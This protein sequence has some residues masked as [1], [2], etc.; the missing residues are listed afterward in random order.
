MATRRRTATKVSRPTNDGGAASSDAVV[1]R[2]MRGIIAGVSDASWSRLAAASVRRDYA[3]GE[4]IFAAG[5]PALGLFVV[6]AGQVRVMR[7]GGGR[8][9]VLHLEGAGATLGEAPM[10]ESLARGSVPEPTYPGT[11]VAAEPTACLYVSREAV[12]AAVRADP[13]LAFALLARLAARVRHFADRMDE[14][15]RLPA[16]GRLASLLL[17]RH[18]A[19]RG[20][21]FALAPTQQH[22][23]EELGTVREIVVRDEPALRALAEPRG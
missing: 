15:A 9:F 5:A 19:S 23:A 16:V 13:D 6:V 14:R 22:A 21:S 17:Q 11:A 20:R 7:D 2:P 18:E 8:P 3:A 10:F 4:T 12:R 1:P